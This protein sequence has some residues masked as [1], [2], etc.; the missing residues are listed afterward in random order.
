M[1]LIDHVRTPKSQ[2]ASDEPVIPELNLDAAADAAPAKGDAVSRLLR[3]PQVMNLTGL[4]KSTIHRE[5]NAGKFPRRVRLTSRSIAW[6][7][8]EVIE[9]IKAREI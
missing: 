9:W 6:R 4:S 2:P 5:M 8:S 7:E 3:L 1:K